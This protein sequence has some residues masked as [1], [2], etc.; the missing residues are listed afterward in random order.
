MGIREMFSPAPVDF[1]N[2]LADKI[3]RH[4]PPSSEPKLI[5]AGAQRRLEAVLETVMTDIERFQGEHRLGWLGKARLGNALRWKLSELGYSK[6]FVEA[7]TEGV[8]KFIAVN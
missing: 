6:Q 8:I 4:F 1:A 3:A 7:L 2:T 5:K